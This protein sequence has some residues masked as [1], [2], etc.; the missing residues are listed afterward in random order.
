MALAKL[1]LEDV[2]FVTDFARALLKIKGSV[3]Y[4]EGVNLTPPETEAVLRGFQLL[5]EGKP[6]GSG[7]SG[8]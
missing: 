2:A 8:T 7:E 4:G 5:R 1:D 3:Q 6:D